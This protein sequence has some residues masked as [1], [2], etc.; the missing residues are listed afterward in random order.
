MAGAEG[1]EK[2]PLSLGTSVRE[3]FLSISNDLEPLVVNPQ[4]PKPVFVTEAKGN[5]K[6]DVSKDDLRRTIGTAPE[7]ATV[8]SAHAEPRITGDG[9]VQRNSTVPDASEVMGKFLEAGL[10]LLESLSS[11]PSTS[12]SEGSECSAQIERSLSALF[13]TDVE[14][15]RPTLVIPLP[16]TVTVE[17]LTTMISGFLRRCAGIH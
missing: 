6:A 4:Q 15:Q 9:A 3:P 1:S 7:L 11:P 16:A 13:R 8:S 12:A 5:G 2:E 17:R 10:A 14:D